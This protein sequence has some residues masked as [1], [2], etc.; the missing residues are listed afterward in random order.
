MTTTT[1][2][3]VATSHT[4]LRRHLLARTIAATALAAATI[5]LGAGSASAMPNCVTLARAID[6]MTRAAELSRQA[7]YDDVARQRRDGALLTISLRPALSGLSPQ[8]QLA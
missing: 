8:V 1:S 7:G 5:G 6:M 3:T 2:Q 4:R